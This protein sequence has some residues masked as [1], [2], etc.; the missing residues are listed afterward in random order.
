MGR[1]MTTTSTVAPSA[2]DAP[3]Q[4]GLFDADGHVMEDVPA[5]V[6]K[7]PDKWRVGRERL[8]KNDLSRLHGMSIFPPLGYLSTIPTPGRSA[9]GRGPKE[10]GINPESW[11]FFLGEVGIERT[12]LY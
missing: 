5:I 10:T 2:Q 4:T 6:A 7:L 1:S 9:L 8:L 12:V 11:E 3:R